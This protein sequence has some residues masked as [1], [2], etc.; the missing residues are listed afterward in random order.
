MHDAGEAREK[1]LERV[2]SRHQYSGSALIEVLH[3]AQEL[4]G[5]LSKPKLGVIAHKLR[6][7][8]SKV[9]GVATFYHLFRFRP[10]RQHT[11]VVCLGTACYV[12][13]GTELMSELQRRCPENEWTVEI[14]RCVG[15]CGLAPV[16]IW[17]GEALSRAT[18]E[19]LD[20]Q[21]AGRPSA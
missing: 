16:V 5:H 2:M 7:P 6:L 11:A 14:G 9:L 13:G 17:D 19:S 3:A 12:A 10:A 1:T 4:Y 18:P 20:R 15:S 21:L 8:P